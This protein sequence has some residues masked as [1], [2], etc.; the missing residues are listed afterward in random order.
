M[1]LKSKQVEDLKKKKT[2]PYT[3]AYNKTTG[4]FSAFPYMLSLVI[5]RAHGN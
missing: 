3:S 4:F 5:N 1:G 2:I